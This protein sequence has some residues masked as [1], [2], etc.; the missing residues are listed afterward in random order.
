MNKRTQPR[1]AFIICMHVCLYLY[2]H[3]FACALVQHS[4]AISLEN[5]LYKN[6]HTHTHKCMQ[7]ETKMFVCAKCKELRTCR[8]RKFHFLKIACSQLNSCPAPQV[9]VVAFYSIFFFLAYYFFI[10]VVH[11]S[12]L[13]LLCCYGDLFN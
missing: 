9:F 3:A 13:L 12:L 6:T 10:F 11:F 4:A 7:Y 8:K 1:Y 5:V 2:V